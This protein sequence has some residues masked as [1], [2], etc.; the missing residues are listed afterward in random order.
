MTEISTFSFAPSLTLRAITKDNEPWFVAKDVCDSLGF[1][2][3]RKGTGAFLSHIDMSEKTTLDSIGG[4]CGGM[5]PQTTLINESG[6]YSLILKS[7]KPEAR[8]FKKWVT[9]VVLPAIRKDGVYVKGEE[10]VAS[11]E[12]TEDELISRALLAVQAKVQR[13]E[14]EREELLPQA[15]GYR[16]FLSV[17]GSETI[18]E[19]AK[20]LGVGPRALAESLVRSKVLYRRGDASPL[21]PNQEHLAAGRFVVRQCTD[22]FGVLRPQ[23]RVTPK[24]ID[25]L[26]KRLKLETSV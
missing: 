14:K 25:W 10:K 1:D 13:L 22:R 11:G 18:T 4:S 5:H 2:T 8:A 12:M 26:S 19:V 24:G 9:S 16:K 3:K 7:R 17:E 20:N 23:T 6:L 15:E 21:L